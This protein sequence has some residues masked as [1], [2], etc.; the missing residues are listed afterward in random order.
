MYRMVVMCMLSARASFCV[1]CRFWLPC[2]ISKK[3]WTLAILCHF[4]CSAS[5]FI[6]M[7][8]PVFIIANAGSS[9]ANHQVLA[10]GNC[11]TTTF[12]RCVSPVVLDYLQPIKSR[13][14]EKLASTLTPCGM[15]EIMLH[16]TFGRLVYVEC[17][18]SCWCHQSMLCGIQN[19]LLISIRLEW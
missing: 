12:L 7:S 2:H 5:R 15:I 16:A 17:V 3:L 8:L 4:I 1:A 10:W 6:F 14:R 19:V 13:P 18:C 9:P 11:R